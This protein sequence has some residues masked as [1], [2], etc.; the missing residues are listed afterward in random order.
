MSKNK[1][2]PWKF[3]HL[4]L[5]A[6]VLGLL[7]TSAKEPRPNCVE[8]PEEAA[9]LVIPILDARVEALGG[10]QLW[11]HKRGVSWNGFRL[12]EELSRDKAGTTDEALAVLLG[13]RLGSAEDYAVVR[14][15]AVRGQRILPYLSKYRGRLAC[16]P[17]RRYPDSVQ[18]NACLRRD[19]FD[20]ATDLCLRGEV[21]GK[22]CLEI[23]RS[24]AAL[25]VPILETYSEAVEK[26]DWK[27]EEG[28]PQWRFE[29][30]FYGLFENR[31][32][33]ADETLGRS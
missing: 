5:L 32:A 25:V 6:F 1:T 30:L 16:I 29:E 21:P 19:V 24:V 8:V 2:G 23:P 33:A 14:E 9:R 18:I 26:D 4:L 12:L 7:N 22:G 27:F 15:V 28:T 20:A 17:G 3:Y 10:K 11:Q 13:Y 31:S